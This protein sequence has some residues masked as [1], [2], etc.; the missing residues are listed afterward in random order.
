MANGILVKNYSP[1]LFESSFCFSDGKIDVALST[2]GLANLEKKKN[3]LEEENQILR[4]KVDLLLE[5]LAE[6]TAEYGL[7]QK[8]TSK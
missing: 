5:M 2:R 1:S 4:T 8:S 6:V 7:R 3:Y